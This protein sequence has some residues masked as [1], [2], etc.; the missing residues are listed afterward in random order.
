M[1][2]ED[3]LRGAEAVLAELDRTQGLSDEHAN[4]LAALRIRLHG[5]PRKSL[6]ELLKAAGTLKGKRSLEESAPAEAKGSMEDVLKR[7]SKK[8]D[9]PGS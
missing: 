7:P 6:E 1:D 8:R 4:V 3:L 9:W 2:D 5:A